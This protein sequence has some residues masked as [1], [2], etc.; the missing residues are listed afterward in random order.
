MPSNGYGNVL[1]QLQASMRA[2]EKAHPE[3][4]EAGASRDEIVEAIGVAIVMGGGPSVVYG[5][6]AW[7]LLW[8]GSMTESV[9]AVD[10]VAQQPRQRAHSQ[11]PGPLSQG[12][13]LGLQH[14]GEARKVD[15]GHEEPCTQRKRAPDEWVLDNVIGQRPCAQVAHVEHVP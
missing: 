15:G 4:M 14:C 5:A 11:R 7:I 3:V 12:Q 1:N 10:A 8:P 2:Y 9:P 13:R 6:P